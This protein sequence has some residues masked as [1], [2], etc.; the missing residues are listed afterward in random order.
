MRAGYGIAIDP[1]SLARPWRTNYPILLAMNIPRLRILR[2]RKPDRRWIPPVPIPD[3]TGRVPISG[4][5]SAA[6]LPD[7]FQRGYTH[8]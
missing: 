4:T 5:V 8:T 7:Q 3:A 6:T 2:I 1:Y